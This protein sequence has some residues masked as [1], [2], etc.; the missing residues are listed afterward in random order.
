MLKK[1]YK[2]TSKIMENI[3]DVK[4][5]PCIK[6]KYFTPKT[7]HFKQNGVKKY[8]D[9]LQNME[10][11]SVLVYHRDKDSFIFVRQFRP[12]VYY[13][14][15]HNPNVR[16]STREK[17]AE[18]QRGFTYEL[19]AGLVDKEGLSHEEI[20]AEE[21]ME[22]IGYKVNASDL[23]HVSTY[24][25]NVGL[26]GSFNTMYYVE[27][28]EQMKSEQ[29]GGVDNEMIEPFYIKTS[30]SIEFFDKTISRPTGLQFAILW[31]MYNIKNKV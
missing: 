21:V 16:K 1:L 9:F 27:V 18:N 22:E 26:T 14:L 20:A 5:T 19:V 24:C 13:T 6:S 15:N 30:E 11:V 29:G 31:W 10:A 4:V 2:I 25:G 8:W 3:K 28:D 23:R 12:P 17:V 7:L